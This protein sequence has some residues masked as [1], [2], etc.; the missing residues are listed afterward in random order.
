[1]HTMLSEHLLNTI[2]PTH[3]TAELTNLISRH[4]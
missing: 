4:C 1:M 2:I 3:N